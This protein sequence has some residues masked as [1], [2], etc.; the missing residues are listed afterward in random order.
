MTANSFSSAIVVGALYR[1]RPE[2]VD[3]RWTLHLVLVI[4][5]EQYRMIPVPG[6]KDAP[7][8]RI[9]YLKGETIGTHQG[10][11]EKTERIWHEYL[12]RVGQK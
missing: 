9:T 3:D 1:E 6:K 8:L 12:E 11:E 7:G 5:V 2:K 4:S 10:H